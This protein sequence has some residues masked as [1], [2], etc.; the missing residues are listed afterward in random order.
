MSV[1][2]ALLGAGLLGLAA[3]VC[4]AAGPSLVLEDR[5]VIGG[6]ECTHN[7]FQDVVCQPTGFGTC[8]ATVRRCTMGDDNDRICQPG[9]GIEVC[10]GGNP[11]PCV[12][13][14]SDN[15]TSVCDPT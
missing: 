8:L 4:S 11:M 9:T 15:A 1:E 10:Y 7:G 12:P 6:V 13:T 2:R 3:V 5:A 14:H